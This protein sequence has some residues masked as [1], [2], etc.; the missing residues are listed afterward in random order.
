M[1]SQ[2]GHPSGLRPLRRLRTRGRGRRAPSRPEQPRRR[3]SRAEPPAEPVPCRPRMR[4]RLPSQAPRSDAR[5]TERRRP[6]QPLP[7]RAVGLGPSHLPGV[8]LQARKRVR[9]PGRS[10]WACTGEPSQPPQA[11]LALTSA[12]AKPRVEGLVEATRLADGGGT[13]SRPCPPGCQLSSPL[14]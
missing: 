10:S 6:S 4:T 1:V 14:V 7:G 3:P 12:A 9:E 2:K 5:R 8:A 11:P 13:K